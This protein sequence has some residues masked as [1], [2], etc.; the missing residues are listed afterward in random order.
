MF[1]A[2]LLDLLH[3][4]G[5]YHALSYVER[6]ARVE[7]EPGAPRFADVAQSRMPR[8]TQSSETSMPSPR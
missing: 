3:L 7:L 5:W 8:L 1:F 2:E 4:C 6:G